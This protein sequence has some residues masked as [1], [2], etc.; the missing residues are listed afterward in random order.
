MNTVYVT[1]RIYNTFAGFLADMKND[2][3]KIVAF[4]EIN[5]FTFGI[6]V[7]Y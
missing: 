1:I 5:K 4:N 7:F 6:P 2:S 3:D